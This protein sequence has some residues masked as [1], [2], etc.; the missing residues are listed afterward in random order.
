MS[1]KPGIGSQWLYTYK[2]DVV[3]HGAVF[4]NQYKK[5][6]P[7]YFCNLMEDLYPDD[8]ERMQ[9]TRTENAL[10]FFQEGEKHPDRLAVKEQVAIARKKFK[11]RSHAI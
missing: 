5:K 1:L 8:F 6:I 11:E 2:V 9:F 4:Q 3:N 7:R 10:R